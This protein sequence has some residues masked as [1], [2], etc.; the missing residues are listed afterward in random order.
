MQSPFISMA[1]IFAWP[2]LCA[3]IFLAPRYLWQE[4]AWSSFAQYDGA[5]WTAG[6]LVTGILL[7]ILTRRHANSIT[8]AVVLGWLGLGVGIDNLAV[9]CAWAVSAW[10]LGGLLLDRIHKDPGYALRHPLEA[11]VLGVAIWIGAW[12]LMLH[13]RINYRGV[14]WGLCM[15][16]LAPLLRFSAD[17]YRH[18]IGTRLQVTGEWIKSIPAWAWLPGLAA[19]GWVLRWSSFPSV[20]FDDHAMRLRLWTS[21]AT[22]HKAELDPVNQIWSLA[23]FASDLVHAA[24]SLMAG[25]DI[26][27]A[28]NL[29]LGLSLLAL[30]ANVLHLARVRPLVQWLLLVLMASTPMLGVLLLSLQTELVLAVIAMAAMALIGGAGEGRATHLWG[31]LACAALCAA[32]KLPAA[33]LGV[34]CIMTLILRT[35]V[36]EVLPRREGVLWALLAL[37]ILGFA[38]LHNY[39]FAWRLTGNPVFPL[40][41][42]IFRSPFFSPENFIDTTWVK[43]FSFHNYVNAFF[44]TSGYFESANYVAGWQYLF[45]LP[46]ALIALA[47]KGGSPLLRLAVIP[48][49]GFGIIMFS[50]IQYWRYL[51][52]VMPLAVVVMAGLFMG[53]RRALQ[54]LFVLLALACIALNL[55]A[56]RGI[57]WLMQGTAQSAFTDTGR[58]RLVTTFAPAAKLN[59]KINSIAPGARVLYPPE[60]PYGATL[61]GTPLYVN[62]YTPGRVARYQ[63]IKSSQDVAEFLAKEKVDFVIT[64]QANAASG[65]TPDTFLRE[66]LANHGG[67]I[68]QAGSF[69]LYR[70]GTEAIRYRD[71]FDLQAA[72]AASETDQPQASKRTIQATTQPRPF[73]WFSIGIANQIK[74]TV[75]LRCTSDTGYFVA[76][77]NWDSGSPYYRLIACRKEAFTFSEAVVVPVN[78]RQG[79]PYITTRDGV[80]AI[81]EDLHVELN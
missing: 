5:I 41:N 47:F 68:D 4:A 52:P 7:S 56:F 38:A 3:L 74:Y 13:Y 73:D 79:Q 67:A 77:V 80:S 24:L 39:A 61:H 53:R 55:Y 44:N 69:A 25:K 62:W 19:I 34:L 75:Q 26:R 12:S 48:M 70:V 57:S 17:Q 43:G 20:M 2:I 50:A 63:A 6:V 81:V 27:G 64:N 1:K 22:Q 23:P 60:T 14:Y 30:I 32:V 78:A 15:I 66:Y 35:G 65:S 29:G 31:I 8:L 49:L 58:D 37:L 42:A 46:F 28:W 76:Q 45:L 54:S 10:T 40:Y 33:A 16:A 11:V 18:A 21:F 51:F 72:L 71:G 59:D 9:V 36:R